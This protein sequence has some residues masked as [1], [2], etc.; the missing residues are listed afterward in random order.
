[1][2]GDKRDSSERLAEVESEKTDARGWRR[3]TFSDPREGLQ[4]AFARVD[5]HKVNVTKVTEEF[6]DLFGLPPA[7]EPVVH[8][9]TGSLA[10]HCFSEKRRDHRGVHPT[11]QT[12]DHPITADHI[13]NSLDLALPKV[14]HGPVGSTAARTLNEVLEDLC[15][16]WAVN[17]LGVKLD[18][19]DTVVG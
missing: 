12:Q 3:E 5:M 13:A 18:A 19:K 6:A 9:D 15:T 2:E 10:A 1:M 8:E 14:P 4:E 16:P 17:H 7:Q 11:G